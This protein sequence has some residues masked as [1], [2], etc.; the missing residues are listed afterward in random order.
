MRVSQYHYFGFVGL[1]GVGTGVGCGRRG[2]IGAG[3]GG[4]DRIPISFLLI[5][6]SISMCLIGL[7]SYS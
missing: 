7:A 3:L 6:Y 4:P 5:A 2:G 1:G